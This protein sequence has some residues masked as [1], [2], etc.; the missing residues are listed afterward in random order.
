MLTSEIENELP[1]RPEKKRKDNACCG[2][3][4]RTEYAS[5]EMEKDHFRNKVF[6]VILDCLIGN[7]T[8][9]YDSIYALESVWFPMEVLEYE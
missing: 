4:Q 6:Y 5:K 2:R 3:S 7:M 1:S 8:N 9:R